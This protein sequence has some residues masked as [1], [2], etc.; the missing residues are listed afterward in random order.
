M[1]SATHFMP[2]QRPAKRDMSKAFTPYS[3]T[4]AT[5][6]GSSTGISTSMK[7]Y[8]Q[9]E[10]MVEDLQEGSSP[11]SAST[12]PRGAVPALLAWRSTSPLRSTP[13]PLPYQMPKTP[14]YFCAP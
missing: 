10:V 14:S 4:S 5:P 2:T 12:P 6:E 11:A 3:S 13:G 9:P 7:E 1:V 8:S